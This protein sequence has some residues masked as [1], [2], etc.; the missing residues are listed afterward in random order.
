M[1]EPYVYDPLSRDTYD[2]L[3]YNAVGRSS[4]IQTHAGYGLTHSGGHS[5]WSVGAVQWDFGQP[6][7]GGEAVNMLRGYQSWAQPADRFS[8]A[9]IDSLSRRLQ[10][11]GQVGNALSQQEQ[12]RLNGYLRS[13]AGR[14]FVDGLNRTEVDNSWTHVGQPLSQVAWMQRLSARDP[15][16]AA[17]IMVMASKLYNQNQ[18]KGNALV[19]HM[20]GP[21]STSAQVKDWIAEDGV[22]GL[23]A[24]SRAAILSGRDNALAGVEMMNALETGTGPLAQQWRQ[25]VHQN[26]NVSLSENFNSNP[27]AQFFDALFR[28]TGHGQLIRGHVDDGAPARPTS[29]SGFNALA[30]LEVPR[31]A[32]TRDGSV[33]LRSPD[34]HEYALTAQGWTPGPRRQAPED[35]HVPGREMPHRPNDGQGPRHPPEQDPRGPMRPGGPQGPAHGP[36]QG[37]GV[38]GEANDRLDPRDRNVLDRAF[39]TVQAHGVYGDA[40]ARN[41]AAA[42]LLAFKESRLVG[43]AQDIGVYG[44]RLRISSFPHGRERE[45]NFNVDVALS[46]AARVPEQQSLRHVEQVTLQQTQVQPQTPQPAQGQQQTGP[47][48]GARSLA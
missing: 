45:P 21:E 2:A 7:R 32:M 30:E 10:T 20:Q 8:H 34:G 29:I 37:H 36:V 41:I 42:G 33:S 38:G 35:M 18:H 15:E 22:R 19:T 26:G 5:G 31:V 12:T 39:A 3:V 28:D 48:I 14:T 13:D 24:V 27:R 17:E 16:Q 11:A 9:E 23:S 43:E 40:E 44:D 47:T 4:E 25:E 6:N 1:S 46:Q